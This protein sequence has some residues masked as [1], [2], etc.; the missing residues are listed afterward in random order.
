M[1]CPLYPSLPPLLFLSI[2]FYVLFFT[3]LSSHFLSFPFTLLLP[4][5]LS[6]RPFLP[7]SSFLFLHLLFLVSFTISVPLSLSQFCYLHLLLLFPFY[8]SLPPSILPSPSLS[9]SL[10]TL[11]S[12]FLSIS[13]SLFTLFSSSSFSLFIASSFFVPLSFSLRH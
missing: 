3:F 5:I 7:F 13:L 12:P 2:P 10:F 9:L 1:N 8:T 11:L 4:Y 6:I